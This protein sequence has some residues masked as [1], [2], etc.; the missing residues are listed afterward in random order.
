MAE[1]PSRKVSSVSS[2]QPTRHQ[3][4]EA[5][6]NAALAIPMRAHSIQ[7][8]K[9]DPMTLICGPFRGAGMPQRS[10]RRPGLG[11]HRPERIHGM[12]EQ[13]M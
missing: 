13:V 7:D 2:I 1:A 3:G 9:K 11:F 10:G 12:L 8:G 5:G 6:A 4:V